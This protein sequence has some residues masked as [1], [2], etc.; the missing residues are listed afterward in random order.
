MSTPAKLVIWGAGG[1]ATV[2]ADLVQR[3]KRYRLVGFIDDTQPGRKGELFCGARILGGREALTALR[4]QGV[5]HL[6]VAIGDNATRLQCAALARKAG[7]QLA[8]LVSA[9][10]DVAAGTEIGDGTVI[11]SGVV[12]TP[13]V[14]LGE[15]VI[16][17]TACSVDHHCRIADGAHICPGAHLAGNV[18]VGR[19]A[20]VGIGSAV[21]EGINIGNGATVGAGAVV[22]RDLPANVL[23]L[24]V[25]ARV[26]RKLTGK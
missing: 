3:N 17:N 11:A 16:L 2:L 23:A 13:G 20:W 5:A 12:V 6:V 26:V 14:R 8:S 24:G 1:H 10:A 9:S 18:S 19:G 7:L 21:I 15:N 4:K 25:P 22:V